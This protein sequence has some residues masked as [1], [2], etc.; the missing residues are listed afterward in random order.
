MNPVRIDP[1]C[2]LNEPLI[3]I[4]NELKG[5][6]TYLLLIEIS[7]T[8]GLHVGKLGNQ[9]LEAGYYLYV[10]SALNG[11][12]SRISRH[13]Q[14]DKKLHWHIDYLT[15]AGEIIG[16]FWTIG[17]TK[18]E[19]QWAQLILPSNTSIAP[20]GGFGSSDCKC[21]EHLYFFTNLL[22]AMHI[23]DVIGPEHSVMSK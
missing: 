23:I 19:C 4:K 7:S 10:G 13:L 11:L 16:V 1:N 18:V 8:V 6:G 15:K 12:G 3:T 21:T 22:D 2:A 14:V 5:T 17:I 20:I 9:V